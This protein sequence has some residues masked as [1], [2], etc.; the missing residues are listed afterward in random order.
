VA[1]LECCAVAVGLIALVANT[2]LSMVIL[3]AGAANQIFGVE[4]DVNEWLMPAVW[5]MNVVMN[6][7]WMVLWAARPCSER[8]RG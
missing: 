5:A 7:A 4:V 8:T 2:V 6:V 3:C 1:R